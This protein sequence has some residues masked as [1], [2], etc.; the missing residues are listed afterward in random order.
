MPD[1]PDLHE[2]T[3]VP[4][5]ASQ[6]VRYQEIRRQVFTPNKDKDASHPKI[7]RLLAVVDDKRAV[8]RQDVRTQARTALYAGWSLYSLVRE[9]WFALYRSASIPWYLYVWLGCRVL[10]RRD[11][12]EGEAYSY[13]ST[14]RRDAFAKRM[15]SG[16][17]ER[18][19]IY[20]VTA[21]ITPIEH[22]RMS[23]RFY[24]FCPLFDLRRRPF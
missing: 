19:N 12:E 21:L 24:P 5:S 14:C 4:A 1:V 15:P 17:V 18:V 11:Q 16:A 22:R 20:S 2:Y 9:L 8:E 6:R 7:P 3:V 10:V 13:L 23:L